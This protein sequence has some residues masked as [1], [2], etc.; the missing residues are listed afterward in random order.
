MIEFSVGYSGTRLGMSPEQEHHLRIE[1]HRCGAT[2]LHHG[3]CQGG[4][5]EAHRVARD[6]GLW[7]VGHP[8]TG[9]GLRA[10]CE[11]D[12]LREV[13]E[14]M[15]RNRTIVLQTQILIAAPDGPERRFSGTWAAV[16]F[17]RR[18]QRP[19]IVIM[20][21][22]EIRRSRSTENPKLF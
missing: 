11:C 13:Q 21:S 15:V 5:A 22:G 17:A 14:Y 8:P 20:P 4:D 2:A 3:D 19:W 12:E 10:F 16:R 7:V 6:L 9:D 1:L 18:M